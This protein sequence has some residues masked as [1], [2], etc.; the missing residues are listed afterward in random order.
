MDLWLL[1]ILIYFTLVIISFIPVFTAIVKKIKVKPEEPFNQSTYFDDDEKKRLNQNY[2]RMQ[3]A[4]T[5]HKNNVLKFSRFHN[6]TLFWTI[7]TSIAIPVLISYVGDG[8]ASKLLVTLISAFCAVLLSF[9]K[10][11]KVEENNKAF[12][13]GESEFYDVFRRFIDRPD[14]F[15][16]TK[17]E[18]IDGYFDAV[19]KVRIAMRDT[20]LKGKGSLDTTTDFLK[21]LAPKE[22]EDT[23]PEE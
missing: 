7:P 23:K 16:K 3:G 20:E 15:G 22:K 18:Q 4:L 1:S 14:S 13:M 8:N 9:H 19:E 2:E 11:F 5:Y 10:A 21:Y 12:R 6:Y 17:K